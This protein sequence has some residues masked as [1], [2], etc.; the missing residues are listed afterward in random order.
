VLGKLLLKNFL[1]TGTKQCYRFRGLGISIIDNEPKELIYF[2]IYKF[3]YTYDQTV[4]KR[5]KNEGHEDEFITE[6]ITNEDIEILHMQVDNIVNDS[7]PVMF[8]PGK[9]LVKNELSLEE[10]KEQDEEYTPFL[11]VK[12]TQSEIKEKDFYAKKFQALQVGIQEMK[13]EI[14]TKLV[15]ALMKFY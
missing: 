6:T 4:E 3:N 11:Q 10:M 2:S 8:F 9:H 14:E 7:L 1:K 15:F 13:L 5:K 12:V